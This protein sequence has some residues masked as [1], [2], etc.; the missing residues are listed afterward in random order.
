MI[1]CTLGHIRVGPHQQ[2][3]KD[4]AISEGKDGSVTFDSSKNNENWPR[5]RG[6]FSDKWGIVVL[7]GTALTQLGR[8]VAGLLFS[9]AFARRLVGRLGLDPIKHGF[10]RRAALEGEDR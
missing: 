2:H 5:N 4:G 6:Q 3:Q 9:G 8:I 7:R 1:P 10:A